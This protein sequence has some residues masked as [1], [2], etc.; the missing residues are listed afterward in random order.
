MFRKRRVDNLYV[1]V[2]VYTPIEMHVI[3]RIVNT[4]I[5]G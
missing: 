2:G 3:V 4:G 5:K 1:P